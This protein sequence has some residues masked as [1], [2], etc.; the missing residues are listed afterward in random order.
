M[1][2]FI[3][4]R[5]S[6]LFLWNLENEYI[7]T[8]IFL[9]NHFIALFLL[10]WGQESCKTWVPGVLEKTGKSCCF[11]WNASVCDCFDNSV[12]FVLGGGEWEEE[13]GRAR[14]D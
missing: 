1:V 12:L 9:A 2:W 11:S 10:G 7:A 13:E 6:K 3:Q 4:G 5:T 8:I 14:K